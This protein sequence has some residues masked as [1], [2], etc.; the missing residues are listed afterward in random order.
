MIQYLRVLHMSPDCPRRKVFISEIS[1]HRSGKGREGT[2]SC[3]GG[4]GRRFFL[5]LCCREGVLWCGARLLPRESRLPQPSEPPERAPSSGTRHPAGP[6]CGC[7]ARPPPSLEPGKAGGV[8]PQQRSSLRQG[9]EG[10]AG[11]APLSPMEGV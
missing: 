4:R 6:G 8:L 9:G 3:A 2:A 1:V 10:A 5:A 7:P 11:R